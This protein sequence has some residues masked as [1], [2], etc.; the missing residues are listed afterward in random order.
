M[1]SN[2]RRAFLKTTGIGLAAGADKHTHRACLS[3]KM[4]C[5]SVNFDRFIAIFLF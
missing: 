2:N 3:A 5:D 4:I 1:E